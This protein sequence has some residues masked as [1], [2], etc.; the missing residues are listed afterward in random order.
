MNKI[1]TQFI[2]LESLVFVLPQLLVSQNVASDDE[3]CGMKGWLRMF[4]KNACRGQECLALSL[5]D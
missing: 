2:L 1:P 5:N 4:C 3:A